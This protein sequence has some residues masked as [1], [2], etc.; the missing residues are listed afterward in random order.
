VGDFEVRRATGDDIGVLAEVT[1]RAFYDDPL[2]SWFLP[3]DEQRLRRSTKWFESTFKG[4]LKHHEV[5]T[6]SQLAGAA[7]WA[8][9][10]R[11]NVPLRQGLPMLA[12]TIR[13]LGRGFSRFAKATGALASNHPAEPHWY[14]EG[15]GTDPS[16]QRQGVG[17]A[18][19][20]P[21]LDRCDREGMPAY[22]ETQKEA[23]VAYYRHHRF[24]VVKEI[25]LPAGGPHMW[26]MWRSPPG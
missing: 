13:W 26:L 19:M 15:L 16:W 9:P 25:D 5:L 8:A 17:A 3:D 22:L 2:V 10:G 1:A 4:A 24:D 12:P 11:W 23:N 20:A 18:L 14:L 6:T 21:I 7:V